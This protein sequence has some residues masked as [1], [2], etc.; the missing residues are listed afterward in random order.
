MRILGVLII[1]GACTAALAQTTAPAKLNSEDQV[2]AVQKLWFAAEQRGDA[3]TL[4]QILDDGFV[5]SGPGGNLIQKSDLVVTAPGP[6]PKGF[7]DQ[8]LV[9]TTVKA[10]GNTVVVMGK[11]VDSNDKSHQVRYS[12]VYT[13][14]ADQ[15]KMVAAQL[16]PV[17]VQD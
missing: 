6:Q 7:L 1:L 16:V 4:D 12:M 2:V 9:D 15:W 10:F 14:R 8:T 13:K 5:G 17:V 3:A 11:I